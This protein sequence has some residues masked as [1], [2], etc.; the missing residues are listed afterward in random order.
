M[1]FS[2]C[3]SGASTELGSFLLQV[4][5]LPAPA[6]GARALLLEM[7][8][9]GV[10]G[11]PSPLQTPVPAFPRRCT[12]SST[13]LWNIHFAKPGVEVHCKEQ[14]RGS[15]LGNSFENPSAPWNIP[16]IRMHLVCPSVNDPI[17]GPI[18]ISSQL[19]LLLPPCCLVA[20]A[21]ACCT[22]LPPKDAG[23]VTVWQ[24]HSLAGV[25]ISW[26]GS[27]ASGR[28]GSCSSSGLKE[29]NVL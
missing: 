29:V 4:P 13:C 5:S 21:F 11:C 23:T 27:L 15:S 17:D 22:D 10:V 3:S 14:T 6:Q 28:A 19:C 2:S 24:Q 9:L 1:N 7:T 8:W 25:F 16:G 20:P 18:C 26:E 12:E